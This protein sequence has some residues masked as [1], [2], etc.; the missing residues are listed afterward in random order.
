[1]HE[2][3]DSNFITSVYGKENSEQFVMRLAE[4]GKL[5]FVGKEKSEELA[6]LPLQL[7]QDHPAPAFNSIIKRFGENVNEEMRRNGESVSFHKTELVPKEAVKGFSG[8]KI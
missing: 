4:Q 1:M 6:L 5:I 3:V 2:R 8:P 7:R